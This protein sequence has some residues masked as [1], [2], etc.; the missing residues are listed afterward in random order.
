[1]YILSLFQWIARIGNVRKGIFKNI[2]FEIHETARIFT[3][4]D[5][6]TRKLQTTA[7]LR[8]GKVIKL[9]GGWGRRV[10]GGGGGLSLV[11]GL[12]VHLHSFT[13]E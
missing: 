8:I 4:S 11:K 10:V 13:V 7:Y 3:F 5:I 12:N 2:H 1:M 9:C 6:P